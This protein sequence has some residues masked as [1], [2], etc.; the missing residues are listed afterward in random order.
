[1]RFFL[2]L[3]ATALWL[4]GDQTC[5]WRAKNIE[6]TWE[7]FKTPLKIGV[8]GG[9]GTIRLSAKPDETIDGLLEGARV[10]IDTD[11]IDSNDRQRDR[12]LVRYFFK[13]QSVE[14]ITARIE[15]V[16]K[17][18][19]D[20]AITLNNTTRTVPMRLKRED[21]NLTAEGVIDLG[22]FGLLPSLSRLTEA[23]REPHK[24]KTWQDVRIVMRMQVMQKCTETSPGQ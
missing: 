16:Q 3:A 22:D 19:I 23:C 17:D 21:E 14:T 10:V 8:K 12:K 2:L 6:V 1:M 15:G 13:T 9:F 4:V 7:A 18:R 24:G 20:T 5:T 11:S